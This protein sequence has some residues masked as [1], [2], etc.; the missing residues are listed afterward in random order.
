[1]KKIVLT[2]ATVLFFVSVA[3]VAQNKAID[4]SASQLT[5]TGKKVTGEH[6]GHIQFKSGA[7]EF[8][9]GDLI[10]GDF[11][12]DMNTI[13]CTDL[14]NEEYNQKLVGHLKSDD[15]FGVEKYGESK[16]KLISVSKAGK[17]YKVKGDLTIKGKTNPVEFMVKHNGNKYFGVMVVDRTLYNVRYG[18]GKFFDNLGDKMIYDDFE[19][20]FEV[21][22]K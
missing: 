5:W 19:I 22:V 7:L 14:T 13:T 2:T 4:L 1:M 8:K 21:V 6:T 15:F 3:L 10:G 18:S 16:L 20:A 12:V 11:V 17:D 9:G